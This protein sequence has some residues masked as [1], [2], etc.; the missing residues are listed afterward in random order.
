MSHLH[1]CY[2]LDCWRC[3]LRVTSIFPGK[4]VG[5]NYIAP[6]NLMGQ[7]GQPLTLSV[8]LSWIFFSVRLFW[9][10]ERKYKSGSAL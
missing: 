6:I 1:T 9:S 8:V 2:H 5:C 3:L 7:M 4:G 10:Q